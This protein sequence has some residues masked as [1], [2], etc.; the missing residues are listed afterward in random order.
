MQFDT[1][2]SVVKLCAQG[3]E[4]EGKGQKTE[5][6]QLFQQAWDRAS[7]DVEKFIAAHY[8]ARHQESVQE[9][10]KWDEITLNLA[11]QVNDDQVKDV[12]PLLYL[13]IAKC[14]E[15]LND[16]HQARINYNL[17]LY[18]CNILPD[19]S[20]SNMIKDNWSKRGLN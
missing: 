17:A 15:D 14:Y 10:L 20:Y 9:K 2:N 4:F 13:N 19:N 3:M 1:N 12:L 11:L 5:A 16:L 8:V 18:Y 7:N 6:L